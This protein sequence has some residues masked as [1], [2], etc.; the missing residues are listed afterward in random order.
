MKT[1]LILLILV[2]QVGSLQSIAGVTK[3]GEVIEVYAYVYST[4]AAA[5]T[6]HASMVVVNPALWRDLPR[7]T[8]FYSPGIWVRRGKV[9][10]DPLLNGCLVRRLVNGVVVDGVQTIG[11][12]LFPLEGG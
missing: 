9:R 4:N 3:P 11:G 1:V 2:Y 5:A 12:G 8:P 7:L 10:F 6:A